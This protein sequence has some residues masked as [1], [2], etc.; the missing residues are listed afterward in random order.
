MEHT[1]KPAVPTTRLK[2]TRICCGHCQHHWLVDRILSDYEVLD[3]E[4][5]PCAGCGS[6]T[7]TVRT[8][9]ATPLPKRPWMLATRRP[10]GHF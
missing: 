2:R 1:T 6:Y 8:E 7:V 9:S 5:R 3:W 4:S 10:A